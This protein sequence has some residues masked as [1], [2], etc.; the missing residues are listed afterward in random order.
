MEALSV[1]R[2]KQRDEWIWKFYLACVNNTE[3]N[4][5]ML[6]LMGEPSLRG[7][8]TFQTRAEYLKIRSDIEQ[9]K[10]DEAIASMLEDRKS[11]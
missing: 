4:P 6:S 3:E 8:F 11:V 9:Q 5:E 1:E 2:K 10:K 7:V